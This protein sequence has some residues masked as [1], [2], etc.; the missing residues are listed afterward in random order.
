M[1]VI[2]L[3]FLLGKRTPAV[4]GT[5]MLDQS[6]DRSD[7]DLPVT[8]LPLLARLVASQLSYSVDDGAV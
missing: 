7:Q 1:D 8:S 4:G 6:A 3:Y 2:M 5:V